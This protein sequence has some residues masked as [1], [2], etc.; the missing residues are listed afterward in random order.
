MSYISS[1]NSPSVQVLCQQI[2][3]W[4]FEACTHNADPGGGGGQNLGK[5]ADVVLEHFLILSHLKT[6][7][8]VRDSL[9][10]NGI[11]QKGHPASTLNGKTNEKHGLKGL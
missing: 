9:K 6:W 11:F 4:G 8:Y 7:K 10:K 3:G 2:R 5:L 1:I